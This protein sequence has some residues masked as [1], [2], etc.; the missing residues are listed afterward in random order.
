MPSPATSSAPLTLSSSTSGHSSAVSASAAGEKKKAMPVG[1]A[2]RELYGSLKEAA[3]SLSGSDASSS[4]GKLRNTSRSSLSLAS[5]RSTKGAVK[6]SSPSPKRLEA[7]SHGTPAA[8]SIHL[9][10]AESASDH[11]EFYDDQIAVEN[12]VTRMRGSGVSP[13]AQKYITSHTK[14]TQKQQQQQQQQQH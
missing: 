9:D 4:G 2:L 13:D 14:H 11:T 8:G 12:E 6:C 5:G 10:V 3:S 1:R 7:S